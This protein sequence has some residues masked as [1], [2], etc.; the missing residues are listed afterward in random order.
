MMLVRIYCPVIGM[1]LL[2]M[3]F[4]CILLFRCPSNAL[5]ST[6]AERVVTVEAWALKKVFLH[7][8]APSPED[9]C[10]WPKFWANSSVD[11]IPSQLHTW[12]SEHR[13]FFGVGLSLEFEMHAEKTN[14]LIL[15]NRL[16]SGF[17]VVCS[18]SCTSPTYI[19]SGR[20]H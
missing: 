19:V 11:E 5:Y 6:L 15:S 8:A 7:E 1:L 4:Q 10:W 9:T 16:S 13:S 3:H 2:S 14:S 12:R 20:F 17:Y 18:Y